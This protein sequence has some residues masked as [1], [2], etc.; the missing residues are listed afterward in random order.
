MLELY[1]HFQIFILTASSDGQQL[2]K[3][4]A[5]NGIQKSVKKCGRVF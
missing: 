2:H 4:H 5:H 3:L 1:I